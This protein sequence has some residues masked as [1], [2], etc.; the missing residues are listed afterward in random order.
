MATSRV[1]CP[2][3]E[4]TF[5]LRERLPMKVGF[6]FTSEQLEALRQAFGERFDHPHLVDLRGRVYLPWS[7][8]YVVFQLG[9]DRRTD[10]REKLVTHRTRVTVDT[11]LCA[12]AAIGVLSGLVL[13]GLHFLH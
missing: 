11:A 8:Y 9:R 4:F 6:T 12:M 1:Y 3:E 7:R 13:V 5:R 10:R 2:P